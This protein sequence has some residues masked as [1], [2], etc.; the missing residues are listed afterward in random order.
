MTARE[1][2]AAFD[3]AQPPTL[4][5][6][7]MGALELFTEVLLPDLHPIRAL[8]RP[9]V[10]G[11]GNAYAA[12]RIMFESS[13]AVYANE[14]DYERRFASARGIDGIVIVS[15]SGGKHA[16]MLAAFAASRELPTWL[17][18]TDSAA[19][20]AAT[21]D[22]TR[23]LLFPRNRE[24]YT[25]N[26]ST[27]LGMILAATGER[28]APILAHIEGVIAPT[29]PTSLGA[30]GSYCI[31]VPSAFGEVCP[32]IRTKFDEL[33]GPEINGRVFTTEELKHAKTVVRSDDELFISIGEQYADPEVAQWNIPLPADAGYA[34][35]LAAGY[36]AVGRI[37]SQHPAYFADA[38]TEYAERASAVF[39]ETITPVVE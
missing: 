18:T 8:A 24:P 14:G 22:P 17:L 11:S 6:A 15:A 35:V 32:M 7:V 21:L 29:V 9:F 23:V 38:L 26:T 31:V 19:P 12:G 25:Y 16:K 27:Y 39:G 1:T 5:V 10:A 37:Q 13:D 20:A 36:Y 34:A 3:P 33:F 28:T 30:Y 2:L 4:D